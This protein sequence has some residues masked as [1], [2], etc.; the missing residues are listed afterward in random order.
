MNRIKKGDEVI[1]TTGRA[2][3]SVATCCACWKTGCW[4]KT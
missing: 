3:A 1:V 2:R 4:L